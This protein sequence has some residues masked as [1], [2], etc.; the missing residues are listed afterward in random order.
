[1]VRVTINGKPM[2]YQTPVLL[3]DAIREAGLS[4]SMPCGGRHSC[5]K[6]KV[7]AQ[8]ELTALTDSERLFLSADEIARSVRLACFATAVGDAQVRLFANGAE[9]IVTAGVTRD[10][11]LS[12]MASGYGLAVD[13]GTTTVVS[14]LYRTDRSRP[15]Q[16][17]SRHN[18]QAGFGAD[19]IS[20]IDYADRNGSNLLHQT[21]IQQLNEQIDALCRAESI[22][23]TE[24]SSAVI[25]GNTTML[26]F[27][28]GL[29]PH[30]IAVAPYTPKSLFGEFLSPVQIGLS[31]SP[32]CYIYLPRSVSAYVG[33]DITCAVLASGMT[34]QN[35]HSLLVD[36]GTNGEMA[37]F[38]NGRLLCCSTAAGPAFEGAGIRMGMSALTGAINRV[39]L[40]RDQIS[41]TTIGNAPA[42]GICGSGIIDAV[43][44]LTQIGLV[45]ETGRID[46]D[47]PRF[48]DWGVEEDEVAVRL[49]ESGVVLTQSDIRQ[50]QLAKA[51][52][53]A[54]VDTLLAEA[55]LSATDLTCCYLAGG[56]GSYI[57]RSSATAI[58]LLPAVLT[59]RMQAIGNAAG[60]GATAC[61]L[62]NEMR[63]ESEQIANAAN[64]VA[65]STHP[66]FMEQY[67]AR[68]LFAKE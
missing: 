60:M 65:L 45:D 33:A 10:Y 42:I 3:S 23:S 40:Q 14:Y 63:V 59:E 28:A 17:L 66:Y 61:L 37:L 27:F 48:L 47:H 44:V 4:L 26:H 53:R 2:E 30:S 57:D 29:D 13:I 62:S 19:V 25:T 16:I 7:I 67:V 43:A 6:C 49:G 15:L 68:M 20:R 31:L 64:E 8:G 35:Q 1:M 12:P 41:V 50:I 38:T 52:I 24:I 39:F 32:D 46:C 54:G 18:A 9:Q 58:G 5:G 56:F 11:S 36:I 55:G 22:R 51:A 21:I 34:T